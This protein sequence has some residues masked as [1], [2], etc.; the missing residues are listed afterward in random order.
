MTPLIRRIT[1]AALLVLP[2]AAQGECI[3]TNL[4]AALP[5]AE[6][7]ALRA[8]AQ[9][10][11]YPDGNLWR[12]TRGTQTIHL[13][14][15]YHLD[16]PRHA[17]TMIR[18]APV[19]AE[20][21]NLLVEAGPA[22]EAALSER[23]ARE[24]GVMMITDGPTIPELLSEP[25]W[26]DLSSAMRDRGIPA[27]MAAK[28]RPWYLSMML[29]IPACDMAKIAE[30]G[31]LDALIMAAAKQRGI[32]VKALEPY[33]TLFGLFAD[34]PQADQLAMVRSALQ[35]EPDAEN[36]SVTLADSYFAEESRLIWDFM[37]VS[38]NALPDADPAR[39][40]AD[41]ALM[42][43]ALMTTRNQNW[44]PVIEAYAAKG[45]LL[46]AF[47]ALHLSGD[48]GVLTLLAA[49]GFKLERLPF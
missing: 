5:P 31:G 42:E 48:H 41:M 13:I 15:T 9:S 17:A 16:D 11:P 14:G 21:A 46:V 49:Q 36:M 4:I 20:A 25:E 2:A 38:L 10:V 6:Q 37:R 44:I 33:D 32:P 39:T 22:E 43:A 1:L 3:G 12:A 26:Q 8:T 34:M 23:V 19:I 45:P 30:R 35:L 24:P 28:M 7:S 29:G 27:F 18:L 40:D 47:G